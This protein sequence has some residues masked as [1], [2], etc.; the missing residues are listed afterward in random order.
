MATA[1]PLVEPHAPARAPSP[2]TSRAAA[3]S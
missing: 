1:P 3:R 2:A